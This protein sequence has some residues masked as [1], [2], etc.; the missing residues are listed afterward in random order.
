MRTNVNFN[1]EEYTSVRQEL[2]TRISLINSQ[3]NT[4]L[5]TILSAWA[6]GISLK[7]E[8]DIG[9]TIS[10]IELL[11][12][13]TVNF[14]RPLIF[15]IPIIYLLP[16]A[17]KSGENLIQLASLSAYIRVFYDYI[18]PD[19]QKMNWETSNNILSN[20]N[21]DRG[22]KSRILRFYNEEYTFLSIISF[23]LYISFSI[24]S[25]IA[26]YSIYSHY[27]IVL[28]LSLVYTRIGVLGIVIIRSIYKS[29]SMRNTLMK[30]TPLLVEGYIKRAVELGYISN[31]EL[32]NV[33]KSLNPFHSIDLT[34]WFTNT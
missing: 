26:I 33:K 17:V 32:E 34:N 6:A 20:A 8:N 14:I 2:I 31:D 3:S 23:V 16:L 22:K 24:V 29:S 9:T 21:I 4:A 25:V 19:T 1:I 15:L 30:Y 11:S 7:Y 18:S 13:F 10:T 28:I 27:F 5:L 12:I